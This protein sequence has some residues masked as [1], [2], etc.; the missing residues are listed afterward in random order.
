MVLETSR[1]RKQIIY[2]IVVN[3]IHGHQDS[4]FGI[5]IGR[6]GQVADVGKLRKSR[7]SLGNAAFGYEGNE[8]G[9]LQVDAEAEF[10]L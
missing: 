4:V 5:R 6:Y 10:S 9:V 7:R 3:F 8:C 1:M 2:P